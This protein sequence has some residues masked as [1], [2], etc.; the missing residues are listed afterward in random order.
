MNISSHQPSPADRFAEEYAAQPS[1][2]ALSVEREV[3]GACVGTNG[4]TTVAEADRLV[5]LLGLGPDVRL[6]ELGSG[7]GWPGLYLVHQSG[8]SLVQTDLPINALKEATRR[9]RQEL[10]SRCV[11]VVCNGKSVPFRT[12]SFDAVT[13]ADVLC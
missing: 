2:A 12:R 1:D 6:L 7:R 11:G 5:D 4:Y 13:H 8:C 9:A 10:E 3:F